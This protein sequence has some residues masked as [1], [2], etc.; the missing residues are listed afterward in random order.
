MPRAHVNTNKKPQINPCAYV[1]DSL[2][3]D[4]SST[5]LRC[6]VTTITDLM[7][8]VKYLLVIKWSQFKTLIVFLNAADFFSLQIKITA[9]LFKHIWLVSYSL[10]IGALDVYFKRLTYC[11]KYLLILYIIELKFWIK[12]LMHAIRCLWSPIWCFF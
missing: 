6:S 10:F 1:S 12:V 2:H 11:P 9:S 8:L 4:Y 3:I 7:F 5:P